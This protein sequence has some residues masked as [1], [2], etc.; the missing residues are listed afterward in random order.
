MHRR[1]QAKSFVP[2]VGV[3]AVLTPTTGTPRST[4]RCQKILLKGVPDT[5]SF[6]SGVITGG[7]QGGYSFGLR[8]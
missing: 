6:T 4:R 7:I 1:L 2:G 8:P 5:S 3:T